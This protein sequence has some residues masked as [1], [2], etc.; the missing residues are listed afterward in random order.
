MSKLHFDIIQITLPLIYEQIYILSNICEK[1]III[2]L[3]FKGFVSEGNVKLIKMLNTKEKREQKQ[4]VTALYSNSCFINDISNS[5]SLQSE[6]DLVR[7]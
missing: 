3:Y 6:I 2:A 1:K 4:T 5:E 7:L